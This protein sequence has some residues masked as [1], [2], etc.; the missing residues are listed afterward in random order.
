MKPSIYV[1]N[2]KNSKL[3]TSIK[4]DATYTTTH[5]CPSSCPLKGNGCYAFNSYTKIIVDR[6]NH[7]A[8]NLSPLDLARAE[9]KAIDE[10]YK[11]GLVPLGRNLRL[12]VS[13][14]SRTIA[15]SRIINNAVGRWQ[16]RQGGLVWAY[17]HCWD[18]VT[19]D[20]WSN[21]SMLASVDNPTDAIY[22]QQNGYAP[23]LVVAEHKSDKIYLLPN[24]ETK[25]IPCPAQVKGI[26]CS[27]CG[28]CL[29]AN[30]LYNS[31]MGVAFSAHG[32]K[33]NSIKRRLAVLNG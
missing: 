15:G 9:A 3:S 27:D 7:E 2:S 28:I 6:L 22:A 14:D 29:H 4:I 5:S 33:K 31:N 19:A 21:V 30:Q 11:G 24:S 1:I 16:Q 25:W 8:E 13:G 10:S 18:H 32:I 17:T 20:I 23:S 12:H 26:S